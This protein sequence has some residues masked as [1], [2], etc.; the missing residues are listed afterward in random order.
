MIPTGKKYSADEKILL[1]LYFEWLKDLPEFARVNPLNLQM[2]DEKFLWGL[3]KLKQL[4]LIDGISWQPKSAAVPEDVSTL[5]RDGLHLTG[6][7]AERAA[8]ISETGKRRAE[9]I[10]RIV[11]GIFRDLG[12]AAFSGLIL[13]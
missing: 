2:E 7:G 13:K 12:I 4:D 6:K 9:E 1:A 3:M 8:E 11:S 5:S 10:I